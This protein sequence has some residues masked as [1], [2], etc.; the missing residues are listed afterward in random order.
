LNSKFDLYRCLPRHSIRILKSSPPFRARPRFRGYVAR[1]TAF[2]YFAK[3]PSGFYKS[4]KGPES[5]DMR[6]FILHKT[7]EQN[8]IFTRRREN[9]LFAN[10]LPPRHL[11]PPPPAPPPNTPPSRPETLTSVPLP[12]PPAA[13]PWSP[14][15]RPRRHPLPPAIL[16]LR[17]REPPHEVRIRPRGLEQ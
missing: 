14:P 9:S 7:L 8:F 2:G 13:A 11:R 4:R 15:R 1:N 3:K 12:P 10:T 17:S 16:L 5:P 6:L